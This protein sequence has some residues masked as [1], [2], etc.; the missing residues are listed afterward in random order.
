VNDWQAT[1]QRLLGPVGVDAGCDRGL[2]LLDQFVELEL[3]GGDAAIA[4]PGLAA[5]LEGCP[6]CSEDYLALRRLA[7]DRND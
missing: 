4:F 3:A 5:H 1:V 2:A 7:S 6:D